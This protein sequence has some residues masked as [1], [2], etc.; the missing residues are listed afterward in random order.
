MI[1]SSGEVAIQLN[2]RVDNSST[3]EIHTWIYLFVSE[4]DQFYEE[5]L[6]K[7]AQIDQAFKITVPNQEFLFR[8]P[9]KM[10]MIRPTEKLKASTQGLDFNPSDMKAMMKLGRKMDNNF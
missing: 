1:I 7:G 10:H 2:K 3:S 9:H 6:K 4:I 5:I 8:T